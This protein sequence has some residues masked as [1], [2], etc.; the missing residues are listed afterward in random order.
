MNETAIKLF[1]AAGA[2][3]LLIVTSVRGADMVNMRRVSGEIGWVDVQSGQLELNKE[4]PK[5][6]KTTAYRINQNE[7][8]VTDPTD[9][10]YLNVGDLRA[11]QYITI[12]LAGGQED[13]IVPKIIVEPYPVS[14]Y[15]QAYGEL[16][17]IDIEAG[18]LTVEEKVRIGQE[19]RIRASAF[20][21]DSENIVVMRSPS[22]EPVELVLKPGDVVKVDYVILDGKQHARHITLYSPAVTTTTTTTTT[23]TQ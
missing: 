11:G 5:G 20:V 6:T 23:T 15:Q 12:E 10:E 3:A 22:K 7:T 4:T 17:S 14:G 18:T 1:F 9:M 8:R 16:T 21:F 13:K 2:A 19:E